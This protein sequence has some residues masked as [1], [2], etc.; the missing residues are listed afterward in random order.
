MERYK[1]NPNEAT[2]Y[3]TNC[4]AP[5]SPGARFCQQCGAPQGGTPAARRKPGR[6]LLILAALGIG[7]ACCCVLVALIWGYFTFIASG[8]AEPTPLAGQASETPPSEL[9]V[10]VAPLPTEPEPTLAPPT[11]APGNEVSYG[12]VQFYYDPALAR[13]VIPETVP[14][15]NYA[16]APPFDLHPEHIRFRF[17]G[18]PLF[19]NA[20][21]M[22][23]VLVYPAPEYAALNP[24]AAE[25][26]A[27]LQ[28]LLAQKPGTPPAG[29]LPFLPIFNAAQF[30]QANM[31][32][33][34]F[35]NG[36]GLRF[37]TQF[38][39]AA[40]PINS[41]AT[42]YT[43]QG[44]TADGLYYVAAILPVSNPI[45]PEESSVIVDDDFYENFDTYI[46]EIEIL[47]SAQ[48]DSS[49]TPSLALL[50][51]MME[52]LSVR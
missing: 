12:N 23:Q 51:A 30:I 24:S 5:V 15:S 11:L 43:F 22:P 44:L 32:Y 4:N 31:R 3:C 52:S 41:Q 35:Q 48:P 37:V 7:L 13:E 20:F 16:D 42:F 29:Q 46:Q 19:P 17:E 8:E 36:S 33:L 2:Q 40:Y 1:M 10:T 45:L 28:E 9:V 38:G 50:D 18:Y 49:F 27:S 39:Q 47:L 6:T 26:I 25:E 14:E 34:N 21:H